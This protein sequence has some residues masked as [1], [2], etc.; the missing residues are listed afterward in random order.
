MGVAGGLPWSN[1]A[2][3]CALDL[4]VQASRQRTEESVGDFLFPSNWKKLVAETRGKDTL[5]LFGKRK[6]LLD[7]NTSL[8]L[9]CKNP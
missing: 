6:R 4:P 9:K 1:E 8:K 5:G 2:V 7:F 3:A